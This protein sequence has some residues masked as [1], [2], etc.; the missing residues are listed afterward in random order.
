MRAA[1][2]VEEAREILGEEE[3][4]KLNDEQLQKLI[5][6][7]EAIAKMTIKAIMNGEMTIPDK[8]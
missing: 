1:M 3:S 8:L 7:L 5:W 6:D 4:S 2:T